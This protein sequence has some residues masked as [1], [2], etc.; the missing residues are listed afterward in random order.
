MDAQYIINHLNLKPLPFEGGYFY[1]TYRSGEVVAQTGLPPRYSGDRG[2][3]TAI[4]YLVTPEMFSAVHRIKSDEVFHFYLGDPVTM[5]Q[6]NP[7]GTGKTVVLGNDLKKGQYPQC[8][9][10]RMIW[11]GLC[12][13]RD[14]KFALLGTTVTPAFEYD[15]FE[16]GD[17]EVLIQQYPQFADMITRLTVDQI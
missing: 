13:E 1:E 6:L 2:F 14:G 17:R 5:L 3:G 9:V 7:D 4:Y 11:Q 15:D 8:V 16:L 12:L 10:P